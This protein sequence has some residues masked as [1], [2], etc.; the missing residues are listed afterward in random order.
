MEAQLIAEASLPSDA[1]DQDANAISAVTSLSPEPQQT[2]P[3]PAPEQA[4]ELRADPN[5]PDAP[6]SST[7]AQQGAGDN[8]IEKA[9]SPSDN[10]DAGCKSP[11]ADT[12]RRPGIGSGLMASVMGID[13]SE[14]TNPLSPEEAAVLGERAPVAPFSHYIVVG[15][16]NSESSKLLVVLFETCTV[17][18]WHRYR[19]V[20]LCQ[21]VRPFDTHQTTSPR[22]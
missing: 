18:A 4:P 15:E 5:Y 10:G 6:S 8:G 17:D 20:S 16:S 22:S 13:V 12:L 21:R 3:E 7:N 19:H 9:S 14:R 1:A 2:E 11:R